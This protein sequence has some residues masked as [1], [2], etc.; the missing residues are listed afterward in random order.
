MSQK[1]L[2]FDRQLDIT[3][4]REYRRTK[5]PV[6]I[7]EIFLKYVLL[8]YGVCLNCLSKREI[9]KDAVKRIYL[10]LPAK[11]QKNDIVNFREWLYGDTIKTCDDIL[12]NQKGDK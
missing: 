9:A 5:N 2:E 3:A 10:A 11:I 6:I 7:S 1:Q 4:I 8:V 12:K